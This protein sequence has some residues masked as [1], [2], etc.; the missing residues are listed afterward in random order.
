MDTIGELLDTHTYQRSLDN[1]PLLLI[2]VPVHSYPWGAIAS[3]WAP[4][5]RSPPLCSRAKLKPIDIVYSLSLSFLSANI[6][7]IRPRLYGKRHSVI[8]SAAS[9]NYYVLQTVDIFE[10]S[11]LEITTPTFKC[12]KFSL[13]GRLSVL[14]YLAVPSRVGQ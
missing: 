13:S 2:R 3:V 6:S 14:H 9:R 1:V 5:I 11:I 10:T 7:Q 12:S 4:E 8:A